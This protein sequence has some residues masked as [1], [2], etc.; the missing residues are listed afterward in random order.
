MNVSVVGD[1]PLGAVLSAGYA[2]LGHE[3][4]TIGEDPSAVDRLDA[5]E[6]ALEEPGLD[7]M[8]SAHAGSRLRATTDYAAAAGTELTVLA[9]ETP[10]AP[11]GSIDTDGL[12]A[13]AESLGSAIASTDGYHLVVVK[14]AVLPGT[15]EGPLLDAIETASGKTAGEGVGLAVNPEFQRAGSAVRDFMEPDRIVVGTDGDERALDRLARLYEPLVVE[16][17]VPVVETGRREAATTRYAANAVLAVKRRVTADLRVVCDSFDVD[18]RAV[19]DAAGLESDIAGESLTPGAGVDDR[20]VG[21]AAALLAE[22]D[23]S[24]SELRVIA[25]VADRGSNE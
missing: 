13:A 7:A 18:A 4:T 23:P 10:T 14:S 5:G 1:G 6:T 24:D 16:W 21:D 15:V 2:D 3:V 17:D 12:V 9:V 11:D 25:A 19:V 22:A 20:L 8:L